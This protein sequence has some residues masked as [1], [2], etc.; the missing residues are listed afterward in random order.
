MITD[1]NELIKRITTARQSTYRAQLATVK[2][3]HSA[4][5]EAKD[6]FARHVS[7]A[8][9][10]MRSNDPTNIIGDRMIMA[11]GTL[12][13]YDTLG[14]AW[15]DDPLLKRTP[16][17]AMSNLLPVQRDDELNDGMLTVCADTEEAHG[18]TTNPDEM[19]L[20]SGVQAANLLFVCARGTDTAMVKE[21]AHGQD[22]T[23][24]R[25][26]AIL[27]H[28]SLAAKY[29]RLFRT[30]NHIHVDHA[31]ATV[32]S[33]HVI[34]LERDMALSGRTYDMMLATKSSR[35]RIDH[36]TKAED[37]LTCEDN[38][39][40]DALSIAGG[41]F[42]AM[43][44]S[45]FGTILPPKHTAATDNLTGV[46][47]LAIS[48]LAIART[49]GN[50]TLAIAEC[51]AAFGKVVATSDEGQLEILTPTIDCGPINQMQVKT[52]AEPLLN[53]A[54]VAAAQASGVITLELAL[55]R[56]LVTHT[57]QFDCNKYERFQHYRQL[58]DAGFSSVMTINDDLC[59]LYVTNLLATQTFWDIYNI[60]TSA[61]NDEEQHAQGYALTERYSGQEPRTQPGLI[62]TRAALSQDSW[63]ATAIRE[64]Y[65]KSSDSSRY[66]HSV[67]T[68]LTE[69]AGGAYMQEA[70]KLTN[71]ATARSTAGA[72]LNSI[73][74]LD[75][76]AQHTGQLAPVMLL[77]NGV[78]MADEATMVAMA[79][80]LG[81]Y[82]Y[83]LRLTSDHV[84]G[85]NNA[86][87]EYAILS[88][89]QH[90]TAA[91]LVKIA[92][93]L[94]RRVQ[95]SPT[96]A[97]IIMA[98]ARSYNEDTWLTIQRKLKTLRVEHGAKFKPGEWMKQRVDKTA[99]ILGRQTY[100]T[101]LG[102]VWGARP[103]IP[104]SSSVARTVGKRGGF[105]SKHVMLDA[106]ATLYT[107][108]EAAWHLCGDTVTIGASAYQAIHSLRTMGI[109]VDQATLSV[110]GQWAVSH[111]K[112]D[113]LT[114]FW[115][116]DLDRALITYRK[117][118]SATK[119][120]STTRAAWHAVTGMIIM[121]VKLLV[122]RGL[123]ESSADSQTPNILA[124]AIAEATSGMTPLEQAVVMSLVG[125]DAGWATPESVSLMYA[126]ANALLLPKNL[127]NEV[128]TA[129]LRHNMVARPAKP[130]ARCK[131]GRSCCVTN[132]DKLLAITHK[133][134]K[135]GVERECETCKQLMALTP[136][137]VPTCGPAGV[138]LDQPCNQ[139]EDGSEYAG[140]TQAAE[141]TTTLEAGGWL[142]NDQSAAGTIDSKLRQASK[143][144]IARVYQEVANEDWVVASGS[145][146]RDIDEE[147]ELMSPVAIEFNDPIGTWSEPEKPA[148]GA[149]T[150]QGTTDM[151][152]PDK[153][154]TTRNLNAADTRSAGKSDNLTL[155]TS[156]ADEVEAEQTREEVDTQRAEEIYAA[157]D[158]A[159]R[160]VAPKATKLAPDHLGLV[161]NK[162]TLMTP[163]SPLGTI[164]IS[165][166]S[167]LRCYTNMTGGEKPE[168]IPILEQTRTNMIH[169]VEHD[170]PD[171]KAKQR[172]S[173]DR[174]APRTSQDSERY[175]RS[176]TVIPIV[177]DSKER[178]SFTTLIRAALSGGA[179][180]PYLATLERRG[181]GPVQSQAQIYY[182][183]T[184][185]CACP[186]CETYRRMDIGRIRD[187]TTIDAPFW[188]YDM[189]QLRDMDL[190][191]NEDVHHRY[192]TVNVVDFPG[193][194]QI[195]V[196]CWLS[197]I[198][199]Y[200]F[201]STSTTN[202][203]KAWLIT[204]E[205]YKEFSWP[206]EVIEEGRWRRYE[207]AAPKLIRIA[208]NPVHLDMHLG[209]ENPARFKSYPDVRE[210]KW[211]YG[212]S[213]YQVKNEVGDDFVFT[214]GLVERL[215]QYIKEMLPR[216]E[217]R[218]DEDD[219]VRVMRI[220]GGHFGDMSH[221]RI[222]REITIRP[223]TERITIVRERTCMGVLK[224]VRQ[225]R[226]KVDPLMK[227]MADNIWGP[228]ANEILY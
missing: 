32:A 202:T 128:K 207:A 135:C 69:Y 90:L 189:G 53:A 141:M 147:D 140:E 120:G 73:T 83:Q 188:H 56:L 96:M 222:E 87:R 3:R 219:E 118:L 19:Y 80:E 205:R 212:N 81:R 187:R 40:A 156:W 197:C 122:L 180:E 55:T 221:Y 13:N 74:W 106:P 164:G 179:E 42:P 129:V 159:D 68:A 27:T 213:L 15:L 153:S 163:T 94:S 184:G 169:Y 181:A 102:K 8:I 44:R 48:R 82:G 157:K 28:A 126:K 85:V 2:M 72:L 18:Y 29:R 77:R 215:S 155:V 4:Q 171:L 7:T 100:E 160:S 14:R 134:L 217:P 34:K 61:M 67:N 10:R 203:M 39:V 12:T 11:T 20:A 84:L 113:L 26:L 70:T 43:W 127:V 198:T 174:V 9:A 54:E 158:D 161:V 132:C 224:Q 209:E 177:E 121:A 149:K 143:D 47:R 152:D 201:R 225:P 97:T 170:L 186:G 23:M 98:L 31:L 50:A 125:S 71:I 91:N 226:H 136:A 167:G 6:E 227:R 220:S 119:K 16:S 57:R 116:N 124:P 51:S 214:K 33:S 99:N 166:G 49:A 162:E 60:D 59:T 38:L 151:I 173:L 95:G 52:L 24:A 131:V 79:P 183:V 176:Q 89:G 223:L 123:D 78:A 5:K 148:S 196:S 93:P 65:T 30:G 150:T 103:T 75:T 138:R 92:K 111:I 206:L 199:G 172:R 112:P 107:D 145:Y 168:T 185:N 191:L 194:T 117:P 86:R 37:R 133:C 62:N 21:P 63:E 175:L 190:R 35:V 204:L 104:K 108:D 66:T 178:P 182:E 58:A 88:N 146:G 76:S 101:K 144:T 45:L 110:L 25:V 210:S 130:L 216:R 105:S 208:N 64:A 193:D 139:G 22:G 36:G 211:A 114:Y 115:A 228:E 142:I 200:T 41:A 46:M 154:L 218:R 192:G 17:L 195:A 165:Y 1:T 137:K 109:Y